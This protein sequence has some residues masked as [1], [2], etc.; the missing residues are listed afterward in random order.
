MRGKVWQCVT[1]WEPS[2]EPSHNQRAAL[3]LHYYRP[4]QFNFNPE[5]NHFI[6]TCDQENSPNE[7]TEIFRILWT[8]Y[9][10]VLCDRLATEAALLD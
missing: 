8:D 1:D 2:W 5:R 9:A 10:G 7:M 4:K 6:M 3:L